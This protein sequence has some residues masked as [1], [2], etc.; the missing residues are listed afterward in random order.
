MELMRLEEFS[1]ESFVLVSTLGAIGGYSLLS[2]LQNFGCIQ[3]VE[4]GK[5][6]NFEKTP[7]F[8]H[9][10]REYLALDP[11]AARS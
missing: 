8:I 4:K 3:L 11:S 6:N 9:F 1:M 7:A 2:Q 10:L 5:R